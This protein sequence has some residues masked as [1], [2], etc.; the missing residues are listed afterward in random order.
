[1][2]RTTSEPPRPPKPVIGQVITLAA[3]SLN[4]EGYAL[5][6]FENRPVLVTG[7][8]PGE[9]VQARVT[10]NGRRETFATLTK[11]LRRSPD[12]LISPPCGHSACDGCPLIAMNY[13]AQLA[14]KRTAIAKAFNPFPRLRDVDIHDVAPSP[15]PLHYRTSA[16][17]VVA[18]KFAAPVIGIYRKNSHDVLDIGD[19]PLHHPLINRVI[20]SVREG[21]RKGKVP[22]Y[23]PRS[24]TGLLRYL[25]VRVSPTENRAMAV[26]VTAER[27][28]NE[29][30]HLGK[31]IQ[32]MVPEVTVVA[33]NVNASAGNVVFGERDFFLTRERYLRDKLGDVGFAISPRSFFQVNNDGARIIYDKVREWAALTGREKV[34]DMYCGIGGISIF[35]ARQ[36]RE[37]VGIEVV[38]AAVADAER[39]ARL[40]GIANCRFEAGDAAELLEELRGENE[41]FDLVVLNPPRKG[42]DERVLREVAAIAPG[43]IIY[44]SCAPQTLARDLAILAGLGYRCREVQP[45]DMFPQTPH[46]EN[47]ALI[48]P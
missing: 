8:L 9:L 11:V 30:H 22:I 29:L 41:R 25:V 13:P 35:L 4:E 24:G 47:V 19:C 26:F 6:T 5:S 42:C 1:M 45:V 2:S 44:V 33:Q 14:W 10:H 28:Y 31:Y 39:N 23:S 43:K 36:A 3:T 7:G 37:V 46:V 38:E 15:Q 21:I 32:G 27:S 48:A 34:L 20:A 40:N 18:G 12:R 17:L 16:K